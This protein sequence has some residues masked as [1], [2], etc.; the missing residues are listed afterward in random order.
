MLW[1]YEEAL[2]YLY[3]FIDYEVRREVRYA[4]EVMNL[5]RPLA[6]L[7]GL[8]NPHQAYPI[9]HITGTKGKGSVGAYCLAA[10]QTAGLRTGLYSSPHLQDFRERFRIDNTMIDPESLT[11]LLAEIKPVADAIEGLTWFELT[12]A[13]AFLYFARQHVD[14]V[15]LEVG[16]GGRLDATNVVTPLV[17]VITS[18][19]YDHTHLLG[20][21]LAEIAGEKAGI[22]KPGVPVIS[23]PQPP[24]AA[25][26]LARIAAE[27]G[28]PL[29]VIGQDWRYESGRVTRFGQDFQ[30][31]PVDEPLRRYATPLLGKHQ[32]LNAVVAL[33]ALETAARSGLTVPAMVHQ[34]GLLNANWPGR[35]EIVGERPWMVLDA[36]HNGASAECLR[37][38]LLT[39]FPEPRP[40]VMIFGASADKDI[41]GMFRALLPEIDHLLLAQAVHPR[42]L[43]PDSLL[44]AETE[45]G[46]S[47]TVEQI[48]VV[49]EALKRA[50]ELAGPDGLILVAGSLF[51]IGEVRDFLGLTPG[52]ASYYGT[53]P[54]EQLLYEQP[55]AD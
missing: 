19:S 33:A 4:P 41:T 8:G 39:I 44:A 26:V 1:S 35:F 54:V 45:V 34:G 14:A 7:A 53:K 15:V 40:R 47:G 42:A 18:L 48:P 21:T 38:T 29:T 24:E 10:L 27:R 16:L 49:E 37:E 9:I 20:H 5:D 22:I 46:F 3:S 51:I 32:V 31:A 6:L 11:T 52:Q 50:R 2:D 23:A 55:R 28:A 13:L 30:A 25:E 12:T 43:D 17:S 36:A